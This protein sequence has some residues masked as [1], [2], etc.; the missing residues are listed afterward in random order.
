MTSRRTGAGLGLAITRRIVAEHGGRL[1]VEDNDPRGARFVIA[2][3][4]D[5]GGGDAGP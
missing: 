5:D 1:W 2:L 4:L 3:P